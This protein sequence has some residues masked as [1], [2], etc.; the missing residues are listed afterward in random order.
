ML[1]PLWSSAQI[2]SYTAAQTGR[3]NAEVY[4]PSGATHVLVFIPGDGE[5][6]T[7]K[8]KLYTWGPL[9]FIRN[10]WRPDFAV[11][12]IQPPTNTTSSVYRLNT[13]DIFLNWIFK[14]FPAQ[15]FSATG[16]SYGAEHW[17]LYMER[18]TGRQPYAF[19]PMS[20]T[21]SAAPSAW[22]KITKTWGFVG[23]QDF[24]YASM[25]TFIGKI[26]GAKLTTYNGGHSGWN[27][28]YDPKWSESGQSIYQF[29][30]PVKEVI[31]VDA[32]A[33]TTI[34]FPSDSIALPEIK[35]AVWSVIGGPGKIENGWLKGVYKATT[36]IRA[37]V[38]GASD[39]RNITAIFDPK[40]LFTVFGV[41][42][43]SM[44]VFLDGQVRAIGQ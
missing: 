17:Y 42:E 38:N 30:T 37:T 20:Y 6:G 4:W 18:A 10:G 2:T 22:Y 23:T 1:L 25:K 15:T 33:D 12:G 36:T 34:Y 9:S 41:G 26:P 19:I 28:F 13:V 29:A 21:E 35:G 11:I 24:P 31:R 44:G 43:S 39:D 32:G 14:T 8:N 5:Y 7:D 3:G 27:T 40:R 16:L